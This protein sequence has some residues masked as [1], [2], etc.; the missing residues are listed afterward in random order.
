MFPNLQCSSS[1]S[2]ANALDSIGK[3]GSSTLRLHTRIG[4]KK[5]HCHCCLNLLAVPWVRWAPGL[6]KPFA[7]KDMGSAAQSKLFG[8]ILAPGAELGPCE[9][10][11]L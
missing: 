8:A 11:A 6:T 2:G 3:L 10:E 9:A 4:G 7:R 5:W 1:Y